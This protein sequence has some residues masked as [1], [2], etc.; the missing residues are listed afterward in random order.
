MFA[1][2]MCLLYILFIMHASSTIVITLCFSLLP[3]NKKYQREKHKDVDKSIH[4]GGSPGLL[5]W[6]AWK[7][8]AAHSCVPSLPLRTFSSPYCM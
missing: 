4:A 3:Q 8:D 1:D 6:R 2:H 7:S 5:T